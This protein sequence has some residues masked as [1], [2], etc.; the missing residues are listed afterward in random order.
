MKY[1]KKPQFIEAEQF[2]N[3]THRIE[4]VKRFMRTT[5][6]VVDEKD[7]VKRLKVSTGEGI[8]IVH[9]GDYVVKSAGGKFY[10]LSEATFNA[11]FEPVYTVES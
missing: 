2:I 7:G 3:D 5:S 6:V 1:R 11:N 9:E 8:Q 10:T 4:K